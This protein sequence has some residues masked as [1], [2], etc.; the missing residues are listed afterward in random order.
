MFFGRYRDISGF[1]F[2][3]DLHFTYISH[4]RLL[5]RR[6]THFAKT[7]STARHIANDNSSL[8]EPS[9]LERKCYYTMLL[10]SLYAKWPENAV[11][12]LGRLLQQSAPAPEERGNAQRL[13]TCE[14]RSS[15]HLRKPF[16]LKRRLS[17]QL[18]DN[19]IS[20]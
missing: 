10:L 1:S 8:R 7:A 4:F 6:L 15:A 16:G 20:K 18:R 5:H 13:G 2:A 14:W 19:Y 9:Y 11:F 12:S 17:S 3:A